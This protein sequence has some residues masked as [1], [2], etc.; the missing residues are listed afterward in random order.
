ML[1]VTEGQLEAINSFRPTIITMGNEGLIGGGSVY[2]Y[3]T[4]FSV[5]DVVYEP[6]LASGTMVMCVTQN[7]MNA[8]LIPLGAEPLARV[9][10]QIER[11]ITVEMSISVRVQKSFV[12]ISNL[13]V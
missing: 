8:P 1:L 10:T 4:G 2:K 7:M 13:P 5:V 11:M 3:N 6:W 9:Q 12:V